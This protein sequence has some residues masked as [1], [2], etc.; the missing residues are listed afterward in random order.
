[1]EVKRNKNV[2]RIILVSAIILFS[3]TIV[4]RMIVPKTSMGY[5]K[6]INQ[7]SS[8]YTLFR[9]PYFKTKGDLFFIEQTYF[10]SNQIV[11][12]GE[13][14]DTPDLFYKISDVK[15]FKNIEAESFFVP[16]FICKAKD[17][18][19]YRWGW[20]TE[21]NPLDEY[22]ILIYNTY[23]I[24]PEICCQFIIRGAHDVH[25]SLIINSVNRFFILGIYAR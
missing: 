17:M 4:T 5:L 2:I 1:M 11:L 22:Y 13:F 8:K 20:E 12:F 16:H 24:P 19:K 15:Y 23:R 9:F 6:N 7:L 18:L 21:R 25:Y 10:L 14:D 3:V